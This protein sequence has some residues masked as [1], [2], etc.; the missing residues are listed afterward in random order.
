ME[1][2]EWAEEMAD[3]GSKEAVAAAAQAAEE[4]AQHE[5][6]TQEAGAAGPAGAGLAET[7][8]EG[9][10]WQ[11]AGM[12]LQDMPNDCTGSEPSFDLL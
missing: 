7:A 6:A 3:G 2:D 4:E 9:E 11:G 8:A 1:E 5:Q 10:S 12:P